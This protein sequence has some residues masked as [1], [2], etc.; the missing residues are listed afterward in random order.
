MITALRDAEADNANELRDWLNAKDFDPQ[1]KVSS[2]T[3][4]FDQLNIK[5]KVEEMISKYYR[6]ALNSLEELN[7]PQQSKAEMFL[8]A[9]TLMKRNK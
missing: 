4:I 8:F 6:T 1:E 2:V 3:K 7:S 5:S 9:E